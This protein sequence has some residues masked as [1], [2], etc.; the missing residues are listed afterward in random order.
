MN[1]RRERKKN[2]KKR[3]NDVRKW[4]NRNEISLNKSGS[5]LQLQCRSILEFHYRTKLSVVPVSTSCGCLGTDWFVDWTTTHCFKNLNFLLFSY[6]IITHSLQTSELLLSVE[7]SSVVF[8]AHREQRKNW[9]L[10]E[11]G[12]THLLNQLKEQD[13]KFFLGVLDGIGLQSSYCN[14]PELCRWS[15]EVRA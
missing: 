4:E 6:E 7:D 5:K 13:T 8:S 10:V 12:H 2:A 11:F 1:E 14:V 15:F 3:N 9:F